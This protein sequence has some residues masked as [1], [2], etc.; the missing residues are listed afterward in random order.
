MPASEP[1]VVFLPTCFF[2]F[3]CCS[4][5]L[6]V[7]LPDQ[8]QE[9]ALW[10]LLP[11][12]G[13]AAGGADSSSAAAGGAAAASRPTLDQVLQRY[14]QLGE[15]IS[16][17]AR[18]QAAAA[19]GSG[20]GVRTASLATDI[21]HTIQQAEEAAQPARKEA[22][23]AQL[24]QGGQRQAGGSEQ[25]YQAAAAAALRRADDRLGQPAFGGAEAAAA[26]AVGSA[27]V[28]V[29]VGVISACCS[30]LAL[31]RR[32]AI[33]E[34]WGKTVR[35]VGRGRVGGRKGGKEALHWRRCVVQWAHCPPAHASLAD[36]H[37]HPS[38]SSVLLLQRHPGID[39]RFFLA[40]PPTAEAAAAWLPAI[41]VRL[42]LSEAPSAAAC[43]ARYC[44]WCPHLP[45]LHLG[46]RENQPALLHNLHSNLP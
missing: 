33:R 22:Q 24:R 43:A 12:G 7:A 39:L 26:A 41:Q 3:G 16:G 4:A 46:Q 10:E 19:G 25:A 11:P 17:S 15:G 34:T 31:Q 30:Q 37:T 14:E 28:R 18:T 32:A 44:L 40:Q 9:G 6:D 13:G 23:E 45:K 5:A 20:G 27:E 2:A 21:E 35:E 1:P 42:C 29:F 8:P 38:S 36:T